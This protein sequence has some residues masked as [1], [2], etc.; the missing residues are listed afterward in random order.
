MRRTINVDVKIGGNIISGRQG[1]A[2]VYNS[3]NFKNV[4]ADV[5]MEQEYREQMYLQF[6]K[7]NV[8]AANRDYKKD[9]TLVCDNGEWKITGGG[10]CLSARFGYYDIM[11]LL[12][13]SMLVNIK[14]GD[15][16][17]ITMY[18]K[19]DEYTLTTLFRLSSVDYN[20][21]TL[22]KLI[23]LTDEEME[24]IKK[25]VIAWTLN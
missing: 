14:A 16:V 12:E 22:A 23:P 20:C 7:V 8:Q 13:N 18:S 10:C 21:M 9:G 11:E 2:Y 1:L 4:A 19:K 24:Q 15:L 25:D 5:D 17:A 6:G 3:G